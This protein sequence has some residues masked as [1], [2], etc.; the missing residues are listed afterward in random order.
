M[1]GVAP[2][3][4]GRLEEGAAA[5]VAL[6]AADHARA[7]GDGIGQQFLDLG[8]AGAV[9]QRALRHALLQPVADLEPGHGG[10]EFLRKGLAHAFLHQEAV[11]ADA[12]LAGVAILG[13]HGPGHRGIEVGVVEDDEG[14]IA[15]EFQRHLLDGRRALGHQQPAD[16]GRAGEGQ[17]QHLRIRGQ[18]AAD[19]AR[20]RRSRC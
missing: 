19:R 16:F 6:A 10:G 13:G 20:V 4:H 11:G 3:N 18:F 12:G 17:L 1:A 7:P 15:A 9:D 8:Q 5:R 2:V 14:R